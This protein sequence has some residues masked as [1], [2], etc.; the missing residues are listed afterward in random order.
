MKKILLLNAMILT[1]NC[2]AQLAPYSFAPDFTGTDINGVEHNLQSYLD[3]GKTVLIDVSATWCGPCW[4]FHGTGT[5][6]EVYN[7]YGPN[8][9]DDMMV[10]FV[11]GDAATTSADL[12]GTTAETQGNWVE[13][14]PYPIIDDA[15][16]GDL[17]EI[18]YFPTLYIVCPSGIIWECGV[19]PNGIDYWTAEQ[20]HELRT[21]C[22]N[23]TMNTDAS[24]LQTNL[25]GTS[26][27]GDGATGQI[28]PE[29]FIM[30]LGTTDTLTTAEIQTYKNGTLVNT[31]TWTGN[32]NTYESDWQTL[33]PVD[34][35]ATD[36]ITCTIVVAS[37]LDSAN[38]SQQVN[39]NFTEIGGVEA[40]A[41]LE[42]GFTVETEFPSN[43]WVIYD[44]TN[45]G[46]NWY[47]NDQGAD[48]LDGA[49]LFDFY[50]ALAGEVDMLIS[51]KMSF[52]GTDS[53]FFNFQYTKANY[54]GGAG[55]DKLEVVVSTNCGETWTSEWSKQG[56][57]LDTE[58]AV[59]NAYIPSSSTL[60]RR[61]AVD[62]TE[63]VNDPEVLIAF[64]ATSGYGN[65]L[66][67]DNINISSENL[68]IV[69]VV[70]DRLSVSSL[71][72]N[73]AMVC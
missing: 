18:T 68:V 5:L 64:R 69:G 60:W 61:V 51:P 13:G 19:S 32:L 56:A 30:N 4:A 7:T 43:G 15:T 1:L 37:D 53:V 40:T 6:E 46:G 28:T 35:A 66:H 55:P 36:V 48:G 25:P 58:P 23:A 34:V 20:L 47:W 2:V 26:A 3:S 54:S 41:P 38:N 63:Y 12:N 65:L 29:V 31:N 39:F 45:N 9:T 24:I 57:D 27:F 22:P 73:Q 67:L 50:F 52:A 70:E 10:L 8:G 42:E 59:Q 21:E 33:T 44:V 14:T 17:L 72:P 71:F 11:E 62:L 49:A 16:I